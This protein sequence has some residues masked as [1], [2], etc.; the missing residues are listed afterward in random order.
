MNHAHWLKGKLSA[1]AT[2]SLLLDSSWFINFNGVI[3]REFDA[4]EAFAPSPS[5]SDGSAN[6]SLTEDNLLNIIAWHEPCRTLHINAPCCIAARCL[7]ANPSFF[8]NETAVFTIVSLYD[9]FLLGASLRGLVILA[10][11]EETLKPGYALDFLRTVSEYGGV[12]NSSIAELQNEVDFVSFYI[13]E[14]FQ[15]IY[16][17]T[18]S[19]WGD[20]E[21]SL[22]GQSPVELDN[23]LGVIRCVC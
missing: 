19:L 23:E 4:T 13:T 9:V 6:S 15:H 12:M 21:E 18:S 8:P 11:E 10:S 1:S 17:A 14:C 3:E 7:L 5:P 22:F 2:L 16:L 20:P